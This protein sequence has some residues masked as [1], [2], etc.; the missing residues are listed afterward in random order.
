MNGGENKPDVEEAGVEV[1][2]GVFGVELVLVDREVSAEWGALVFAM[3]TA[4]R[5]CSDH[6]SGEEAGQEEHG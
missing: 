1:K 5:D 6:D 4:M 3:M 2:I